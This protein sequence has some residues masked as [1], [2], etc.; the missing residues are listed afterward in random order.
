M[1]RIAINEVWNHDGRSVRLAVI[2]AKP[3][4][5]RSEVVAWILNNR[6]D[7]DLATTIDAHGYHAVAI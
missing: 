3:G 6:P 5:E 2:E 1:T 4:R 7:L